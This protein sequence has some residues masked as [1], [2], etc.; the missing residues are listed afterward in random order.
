MGFAVTFI[1]YVAAYITLHFRKWSLCTQS[2]QISK[3]RFFSFLS[4]F[5]MITIAVSV[6]SSFSTYATD[7]AKYT[8]LFIRTFRQIQP[9]APGGKD[10]VY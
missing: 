8:E 9:A 2:K 3:Q 7:K 4:F 6:S 5:L 1:I 10:N